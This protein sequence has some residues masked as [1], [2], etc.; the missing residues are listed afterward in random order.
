MKDN[1]LAPNLSENEAP[2]P[3]FHVRLRPGHNAH[4]TQVSE[5]VSRLCWRTW[6]GKFR[7]FLMYAQ[8]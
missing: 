8:G 7:C 3:V 2:F 6:Q 5:A 4:L 1:C